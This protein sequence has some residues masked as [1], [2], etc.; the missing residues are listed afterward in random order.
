M[1]MSQYIKS[2]TYWQELRDVFEQ[3]SPHLNHIHMTA[4]LSGLAKTA[5]S[6]ASEVE[7]G[8]YTSLVERALCDAATRHIDRQVR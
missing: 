2:C 1:L 3:H 8:D 6:G 4:L 5:P 7:A